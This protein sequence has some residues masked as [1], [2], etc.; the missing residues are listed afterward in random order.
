MR[1]C[2]VVARRHRA[3]HVLLATWKKGSA[4][5]FYRLRHWVAEEPWGEVTDL[6]AVFR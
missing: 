3:R 1:P 4:A 5:R 6:E 2:G